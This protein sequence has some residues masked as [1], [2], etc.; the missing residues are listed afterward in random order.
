MRALACKLNYLGMESSPAKSTTGDALRDRDE[1][2][3]R[4]FYF[5]LIAHFSPFLLVSRKMKHRK[6]GISFEEFY[7]ISEFGSGQ[8]DSL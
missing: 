1:E 3:F 2:L 6:K 8:H 5:A 7:A 4:Q